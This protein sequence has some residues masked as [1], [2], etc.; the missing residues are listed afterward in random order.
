MIKHAVLM[1]VLLFLTITP[2]QAQPTYTI[3]HKNLPLGCEVETVAPY[4]NWKTHRGNAEEALAVVRY[5]NQSCNALVVRCDGFLLVPVPAWQ[6]HQDKQ[7]TEVLVTKAEG[8]ASTG[9]FPIDA[10]LRR[11]TARADYRLLKIN[12]H[13]LRSLPLLASHQLQKDTPLRV[14]W[15]TLAEDG[16][17][18]KLERRRALCE[19]LSTERNAYQGTLTYQEAPPTMLPSGAIVVDE[20]SGAAVGMLTD[21]S[22]PTRFSHW[23]YWYDII[24]EVGLAPDREA[25][26]LKSPGANSRMVLVKGGPARR[27]PLSANTYGTDIVCCADFYCDINPVTNGEWIAWTGTLKDP[28]PFPP[29]WAARQ[30]PPANNPL[31]PVCGA[32]VQDMEY[33]AATHSKR[34]ITEVEFLRAAYTK[35]LT[36]LDRMDADIAKIRDQLHPLVQEYMQNIL[37]RTEEI[38]LQA[39][40]QQQ[41]QPRPDPRAARTELFIDVSDITARFNTG[42]GA[43]WEQVL[44]LEVVQKN[45]V[46]LPGHV[47]SVQFFPEDKSEAGVRHVTLNAPE[48]CQGY[49]VNVILADKV[50]PSGWDPF[51]SQVRMETRN[52]NAPLPTVLEGP[53]ISM[54]FDPLMNVALWTAQFAVDA[55]GRLNMR[56]TGGAQI[57]NTTTAILVGALNYQ[58]R[59]KALPAFRCVR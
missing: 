38:K 26:Q 47:H 16:K 19:Q 58:Y 7:K 34:M 49:A 5:G 14:V 51:L 32:R 21:G 3:V 30:N 43:L 17:T 28:P 50:R 20:A 6:A 46:V 4:N 27:A 12:D 24:N 10:A 48:A 37:Q 25:A 11:K 45:G 53:V 15:A 41:A 35:D 29:T 36:W 1:L 54:S 39:R 23:R 18:L 31:L 2:A 55:V 52:A 13:H 42:L 57:L 59:G 9:P 44:S 8:E 40:L 56:V 33:Y 22:Q